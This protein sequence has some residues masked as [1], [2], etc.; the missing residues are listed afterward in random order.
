MP[1]DPATASFKDHFSGHADAYARYRPNYPPALFAWLAGEAPARRLA[2]DCA[3]GNGQAA[4]ALAEHFARVEATDASE[5]QLLQAVRHPRV[6]YTVAPAERSGLEPASVDLVTVAQALHWFDLPAFY[7]EVAR[8]LV[9]GGLLAVWGYGV[10]TAGAEVDAV[11][12]H[13]YTDVVGPYWP[14]ERA[15][16][17]RGYPVD[18]PFPR[19]AAPPFAMEQAWTADDVVGYLGT[20]SAVQRYRQTHGD[21]PVAGVEPAL[22]RAWGAGP[23]PVRWPLFLHVGRAPGGG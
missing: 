8:V 14:P 9:P 13:L 4:V 15:A 6:A 16:L 5:R 18:L 3:T 20:W 1:A 23:R 12:G 19:V 2:W 10:F 7:A 11:V 21:D 22:R 17:D